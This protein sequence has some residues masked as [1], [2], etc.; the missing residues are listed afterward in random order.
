MSLKLLMRSKVQSTILVRIHN[1][2]ICIKKLQKFIHTYVKT[3]N[4]KIQYV[5]ENE[6]VHSEFS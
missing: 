1:N 2:F 6:I 4:M 3:I 5:R